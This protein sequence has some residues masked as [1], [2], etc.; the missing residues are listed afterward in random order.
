VEATVGDTIIVRS[1]HIGTGDRRGE[2]VELRGQ[3]GAPPWLVRW[4]H[5]GRE[6]LYFPASD[7]RV[8]PQGTSDDD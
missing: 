5:D 6:A 3:G 7:A 1:R 4:A 8:V 2:V